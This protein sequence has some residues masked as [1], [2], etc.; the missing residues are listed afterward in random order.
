VNVDTD[1]FAAITAERDEVRSD[2]RI[3]VG[4][5]EELTRGV[6]LRPVLRSVTGGQLGGG[7]H[8]RPKLVVVPREA[9]Q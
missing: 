8:R 6:P 7:R 1:V 5:I 9:A 3:L 2:N 4:V